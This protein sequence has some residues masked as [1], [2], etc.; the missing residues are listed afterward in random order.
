MGMRVWIGMVCISALAA[1]DTGGDV[2]KALLEA[3]PAPSMTKPREPALE[4]LDAWLAQ[5]NSEQSPECIAYY[6]RAVDRVIHLLQTERPRKGVRVFQLYS[7]SVL[8][9]TA[10]CVVAIDLDQG[11]N[12]N[13]HQ[14]PEEEGVA[15]CMTDA[16]VAALAERIDYA[17]HTHEH[18]DH[19]DYEITQALLA[20]GKTVVATEGTKHLWE[21]EPWAAKIV[22]PGQTLGNPQRI[23][24]VEAEVLWD[25]QWNDNAHTSGTPCNAYLITLPEGITIATKGDINCALQFFGWLD[26]LKQ[27]GHTI[28]VLTGSPIY[29]HGVSLV[30]EID[31]LEAPLWLPAHNWEFVHR[32]PGD[33]Y[34][35]VAPYRRTYS[36]LRGLVKH[37]Q[38]NVLSWG[39][40]IDIPQGNG[41]R[42]ARKETHRAQERIP[43]R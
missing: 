4:S 32:H 25:H 11:P 30:S 14:T 43:S 34:G 9:Q 39:E 40:Y 17:F 29:W 21:N 31:A 24:R 2:W 12:E 13:L 41:G 36:L 28:D 35:H 7:S 20:R 18:A 5:P 8:F 37:G 1:A 16:Q 22:V 42:A 23:G 19:I 38:V 27:K 3:P 6:R 15:F 33:T 10:S 26:V